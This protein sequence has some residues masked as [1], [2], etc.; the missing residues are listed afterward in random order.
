MEK[1]LERELRRRIRDL[2]EDVS[3]LRAMLWDEIHGC[4]GHD[5]QFVGPDEKVE[6]VQEVHALEATGINGTE[7]LAAKL[8]KD[9]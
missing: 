3:Y 1:Q 7:D 9:L 5:D 6:D 8:L 2:R 4:G